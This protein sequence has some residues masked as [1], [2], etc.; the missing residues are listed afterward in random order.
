VAFTSSRVSILS[1]AFS[2]CA[3][4]GGRRLTHQQLA[5]CRWVIRWHTR[6]AMQ[7]RPLPCEYMGV[8]LRLFIM[9]ER[10]CD[11]F[12]TRVRQLACGSA[13]SIFNA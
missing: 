10:M 3:C 8:R 12:N 5:S 2:A 4:V 13:D 1:A 6:R 7:K 11:G 9:C